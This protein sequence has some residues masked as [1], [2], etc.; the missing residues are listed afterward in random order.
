MLKIVFILMF[1]LFAAA[2]EA[3]PPVFINNAEKAEQVSKKFNIPVLIIVSADWCNPCKKLKKEIS[4]NLE[5]LQ[6]VIILNIDFDT[7]TEIIKKYQ[8]N[9]IPTIISNNKKYEGYMDIYK[10]KKL[11]R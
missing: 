4:E 3:K 9:K 7:N 1:M 2:V 8:I 5:L 10:I 6:D 11:L